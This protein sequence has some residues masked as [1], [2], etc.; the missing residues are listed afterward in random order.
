MGWCAV[1]VTS[2]LCA[3]LQ[4]DININQREVWNGVISEQFWLFGDGGGCSGDS[5]VDEGW[6]W[7]T[8]LTT[9]CEL[10]P[11]SC[12]GHSHI[13]GSQIIKQI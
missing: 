3:E 7:L 11:I 5:G 10:V 12:G 4:T 6:R 9:S 8:V 2:W 1:H 13:F